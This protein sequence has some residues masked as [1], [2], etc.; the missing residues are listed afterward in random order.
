[1]G[2]TI[3]VSARTDLR[4]APIILLSLLWSH[5][6]VNRAWIGGW[7]KGRGDSNEFCAIKDGPIATNGEN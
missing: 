5:R 1:M 7:N 4:V 2:S 6:R 3:D